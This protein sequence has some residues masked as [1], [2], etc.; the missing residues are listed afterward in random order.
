M[1]KKLSLSL[2]A[3]LTGLTACNTNAAYKNVS[4][5]DLK[6]A[7]E[8][9]RLILDVRQPNE[10]SDGHVP[11][12]KLIPLGELEARLSDVP[13]DAAVY[14]ICR[15]GNR[16]KTASDILTKNGKTDVRNVQ[17]GTLAWQAA[18]FPVER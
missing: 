10:F 7:N 12:A 13:N 17:G 2:I 16:S 11:G 14:V 8:P 3:A 9:N 4:V 18:G 1:F 15:S 5:G 6:A